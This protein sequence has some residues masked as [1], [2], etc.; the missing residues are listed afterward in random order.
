MFEIK[1]KT[2]WHLE[3][4]V[5]R[6]DLGV[7]VFEKNPPPRIKNYSLMTVPRLSLSHVL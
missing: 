7:G 4:G 3:V 5:S 6:L 1:S 2:C